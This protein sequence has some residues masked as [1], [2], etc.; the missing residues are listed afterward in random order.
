MTKNDEIKPIFILGSGRS[1]TSVITG[2][3]KTGGDIPGFNEGHFLPLMT[4]LIKETNRFFQGKK[5]LRKDERHMITHINQQVIEDEII[6]IFRKQCEAICQEKIWL[7]KSPDAAM[8]KAVPYLKKAWPK[9]RYLYAKRRGIENIISRLKKFPHVEFEKHCIMWAEC[10]ESW[11]NVKEKI[12]ECSIEIE[13]REIALNPE[14]TAKKIGE[15]L[16]LEQEK[17]ERIA[18]IFANKRPQS[19]GGVEKEEAIDIKE[20]GWTNEQIQIFRKYC[21]EISQKFGYSETS[22]YYL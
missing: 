8:I 21:G 19:T 10:M 6:S 11:L 15:F 16:E 18:D 1:G 5:N 13:Q 9:G 22:D 14:K 4:F 3:L 2:A 20:A 17:I 7:D 12:A